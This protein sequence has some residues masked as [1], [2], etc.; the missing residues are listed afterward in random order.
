MQRYDLIV[1]GSGPGGYVAA[2]RAA[3]LGLSVALVEKYPSLGGTCLNVGCIPSKTL[4][5]S[6]EKFYEAKKHFS[7]HGILLGEISLSWEKM[8]ARKGQVVKQTVGGVEYLMKKNKVEVFYGWGRFVSANEVAVDGGPTLYGKN[9]IIATG[10]KPS[11]LPGIPIDKKR[12]ITSTEALSLP[13]V[14]KKMVIIG[15][16][17]I[18]VEMASIYGRLGTEITIVEFLDRLLPG[19]DADAGEEVRRILVGDY[20]V[21]VLLGHTAEAAEV[22]EKEVRLQ[23]SPRKGGEPVKIEADY[24]LV[25]VGR[26]PYTEGLQLEKAGLATDERGRIPV[27]EHLQT[28]VPHIYAIGDV[29]HGPMLAHKASEDGIFVAERLAGRKPH[30]DYLQVPSVVY[31]WPEVASVGYTEE[32]LQKEGR[33][34]RVGKFPYRAS[35]RARAAHET[36]GFV[37]VLADPKTDQLLGMHIVGPRAADLISVGVAGI[38]YGASAEDIFRLPLAHPTFSEALKEAALAASEGAPIH[39]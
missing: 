15:G 29:I 18:G 34:Y 1:I 24:V 26:R 16:G 6:S 35:G 21:K 8:L 11:P 37:K 30:L 3:Q 13:E 33:P 39:L 25:A 28:A 38:A 5:D 22:G 31:I 7:E 36:R 17:V 20:G 32:A 14:P 4:L 27:N 12:I 10:S 9:I 23:V 19:M 2:I